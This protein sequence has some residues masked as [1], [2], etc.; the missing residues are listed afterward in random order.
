M[1]FFL[2]LPIIAAKFNRKILL[3]L[4][5][6]SGVMV[7]GNHMSIGKVILIRVILLKINFSGKIDF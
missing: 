5:Y 6:F 3:V 4:V 2:T 1:F 7:Q